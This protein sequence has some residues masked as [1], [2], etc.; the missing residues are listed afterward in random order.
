MICPRDGVWCQNKNE[1][2][3]IGDYDPA[4]DFRWEWIPKLVFSIR[5]SVP[6][7][8]LGAV[9]YPKRV[10][11]TKVKPEQPEWM[12]F[13]ERKQILK[14][15]IISILPYCLKE[16][17]PLMHSAWHIV[18]NKCLLNWVC[19]SLI[20]SKKSLITIRILTHAPQ[21]S[22]FC[23]WVFFYFFIFSFVTFFTHF[24]FYLFFFYLRSLCLNQ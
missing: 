1:L 3:I 9:Q 7:R 6:G 10:E 11:N 21:I 15:V 13:G 20:S 24:L 17:M 19:S 5:I 12:C 4:A 23:F 2:P 16:V 8:V 22:F 14:T 18:G